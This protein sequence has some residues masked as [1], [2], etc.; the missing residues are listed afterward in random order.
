MNLNDQGNCPVFQICI[1]P[2]QGIC[3]PF[4]APTFR[5]QLNKT[6]NTLK[7]RDNN[8]M[9]GGQKDTLSWE[10]EKKE[11]SPEQHERPFCCGVWGSPRRTVCH[12]EMAERAGI[13]EEIKNKENASERELLIDLEK[14]GLEDLRIILNQHGFPIWREMPGGPHIDA[15]YEIIFDFTVWKN[16]RLIACNK[17]VNVYVNAS[18]NRPPNVM[19]CPDFAIYGP[20]RLDGHRIRKVNG[21]RMNP[22]VIIQFSWTSTF[23]NKKCAIDDMMNYAGIGEYIHQGR[24]NVA[25]LIKALRRGTSPEAPVYGF[26][27]FRV[28]QDQTTPGEP[29]LRYR[30]GGQE[31]TVISITPASMGLA[32]DEGE[33]FII[34][35]SHI[36]EAVE[37][38]EEVRFVP[39]LGHEM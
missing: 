21:K 18:F 23:A 14:L 13:P 32:G 31:D 37:T 2:R 26:D 5:L 4:P 17:E 24:P 1:F 28:E 11:T 22:H 15:V 38:D 30:V 35:L 9:S 6:T 29:A 16:G 10:E 7:L 12:S 8:C 19:R 20:D 33:P 34:A 3:R 27:V 39:A 25:Y 36:R